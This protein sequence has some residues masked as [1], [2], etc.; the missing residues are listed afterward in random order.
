[1]NDSD[2]DVRSIWNFPR[3]YPFLGEAGIKTVSFPGSANQRAARLCLE[4]D[5][6]E[7]G[8]FI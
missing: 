8:L 6:G 3:R 1:M 5:H 7:Q 4:C 2:L